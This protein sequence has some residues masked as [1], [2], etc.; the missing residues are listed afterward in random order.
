M[1]KIKNKDK[2]PILDKIIEEIVKAVNPV[3]I[4]LFGSISKGE[5]QEGSD[6]DILVLK[7]NISQRRKAAQKIYLS[8]NINA[9]VDIIVETPE[10][11]DILK[12]NPFM[13]YYEIAKSGRLIYER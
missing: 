9:S 5:N 3:K 10:R 6:F 4:I 1:G 11:F 8:L 13:I 7:E 12:E 2:T